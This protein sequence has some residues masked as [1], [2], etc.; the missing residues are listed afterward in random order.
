MER[1]NDIRIGRL[2][3]CTFAQALELRKRGFEQ[4]REE[5]SRYYPNIAA[6]GTE[7]TME[8]LLSGFARNGVR[9]ELSVV[10][11]V[12]DRP[13][14]FVFV[15]VRVVGGKKLAWN[16]GTGVFPEYRGL[17]LA[18]LMMQE[19][20]RILREQEVD[21]AVLEVVTGNERAIAAYKSGGFRIVDRLAAMS[22]T[23]PLERPFRQEPTP[24]QLE[25]RW[26]KP[27]VAGA[28][29]FYREQAA[30]GCMWHSQQDGDALIVNERQEGEGGN[31]GPVAYA[32][33]SRARD[34]DGK[35]K[36]VVFKQ[37]EVD[38]DRRSDRERLLRLI[39]AE[40]FGPYDIAC[41]RKAANL[42]MAHP[43]V[44]ELLKEAGFQTLHEQYLMVLE[45][46]VESSGNAE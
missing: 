18:K 7:L 5:M 10:G 26:T 27:A 30:W 22:R 6:P 43:D 20:N 25:L 4:Y 21:L 33:C 45:K 17:G 23:E 24:G 38:P 41:A 29:P 40:C 12:N 42:S 35:L 1:Q 11:Y 32:L 16:G 19:A 28:L 2:H 46:A 34:A 36:S 3:H 13:V 9:P 39:L 37:C 8:Q 44:I 14:G 31:G 15:A